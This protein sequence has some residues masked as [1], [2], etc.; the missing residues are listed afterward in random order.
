MKKILQNNEHIYETYLD[1]GLLG[2]LPVEVF[3]LWHRQMLSNDPY[4][5]QNRG[6]AEVSAVTVLI[7]GKEVDVS[8]R[9]F[10]NQDLTDDLAYECEEAYRA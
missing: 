10:K 6:Y 5:V 8:D 4:Q 3:Y 9:V 7:D 2:E 1:F